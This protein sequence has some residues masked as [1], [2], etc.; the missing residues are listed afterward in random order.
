MISLKA[1]PLHTREV[2]AEL[3]PRYLQGRLVDVGAG[4]SKY[5]D[6]FKSYISEYIACDSFDAPHIDRVVDAHDLSYKDEE[7]DTVVCTM[8]LEHVQK[9]WI[10]A[11]EPPN[12]VE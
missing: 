4:S 2:L 5:K 1:K 12:S 7:F 10:V 9:P 3:A 11:S 6:I 8:V